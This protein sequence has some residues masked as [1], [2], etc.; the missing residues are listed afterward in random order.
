MKKNLFSLLLMVAMISGFAESLPENHPSAKAVEAYLKSIVAEDWKSAVNLISAEALKRKLEEMVRAIKQV[1]TMSD[2]KRVLTSIGLSEISELEKM[3]PRDFYLAD[4][5]AWEKRVN[6]PA[7][8]K[9]AK[10]DSLKIDILGIAK[11]SKGGYVHATVRTTQETTTQRIEEIFLISLE[12]DTKDG[13]KWMVIPDL[14]ERP[15]TTELKK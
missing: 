11:D 1:P 13:S 3:T 8:E 4:R 10:V 6:L 15:V 2:E 14:R 12:P 9:K 5:A 7:A